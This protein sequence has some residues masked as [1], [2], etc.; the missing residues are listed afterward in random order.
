MVKNSE[1]TI[2]KAGGGTTGAG[3][4]FNGSLAWAICKGMETKS[5]I[6][7]QTLPP[8]CRLQNWCSKGMPTLK[9]QK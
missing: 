2:I 1:H 9:I 3:D 7:L 6:N 4:T 5:A 8:G